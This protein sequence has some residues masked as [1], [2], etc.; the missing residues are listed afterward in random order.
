MARSTNASV[1]GLGC[2]GDVEDLGDLVAVQVGQVHADRLAV[3]R[4][5]RWEAQPAA[6]ELAPADL[7]LRLREDIDLILAVAVQVGEVDRPRPTRLGKVWPAPRPDL[8]DWR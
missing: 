1:S 5:R 7:L 6:D 4:Q 8:P 3:D 2:T